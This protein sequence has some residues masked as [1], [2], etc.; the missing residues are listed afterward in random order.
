M[1]FIQHQQVCLSSTQVPICSVND[2]D[3]AIHELTLL[4]SGLNTA[5]IDVSGPEEEEEWVDRFT[6]EGIDR[7]FKAN[8]DF[9]PSIERWEEDSRIQWE[10]IPGPELFNRYQIH[11]QCYCE[12]C[13]EY[14]LEPTYEGFRQWLIDLRNAVT[15]TETL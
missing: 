15:P 3:R 2:I 7:Q 4:K 5:Q 8:V 9:R 6:P 14:D 13:L 11:A 12:G 1:F 10:G